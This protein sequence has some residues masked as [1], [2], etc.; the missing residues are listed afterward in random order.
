[1]SAERLLYANNTSI[2]REGIA[3]IMEK[4][5]SKHGHAFLGAVS[6]V[7]ELKI[8]LTRGY[9]PTVFLLDPWLPTLDEG[10]EAIGIMKVMSPGTKVATLPSMTGLHSVDK[11]FKDVTVIEELINYLNSLQ[12]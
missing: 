10:V 3:G 9:K 12:H 6:S 7:E 2:A 1:M 8:V 11:K 4:Y 5:V